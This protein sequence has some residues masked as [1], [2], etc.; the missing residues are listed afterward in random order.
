MLEKKEEWRKPPAELKLSNY[1]VSS[2]GRVKNLK[3]NEII[4]FN[5]YA[6]RNGYLFIRFAIDTGDNTYKAKTFGVHIIIIITFLGK[7]NPDQTV[8][9]MNRIR[10]DN[11]IENLRWLTAKEQAQNRH[12]PK[13]ISTRKIIQYD[14]NNN[15]IKEWDSISLII[16]TLDI[17]DE[18][19]Y[20]ACDKNILLLNSFWKYKDKINLPNEDWTD[21]IINNHDI[22]ASNKGR[23]Q[24]DLSNS[25]RILDATNTKGNGYY[26]VTIGKKQYV[27]QRL[28]CAA[29]KD[30]DVNSKLEINHIDGN[31]KNNNIE[32][33]EIVTRKQNM[34]HAR[35]TGLVPKIQNGRRRPV[36]RSNLD[37]SDEK[38]YATVTEA[39]KENNGDT[40]SISKA[41]K[42]IRKTV[43]GYKYR[44]A[45]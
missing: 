22:K 41:C 34:K 13:T 19:I 39:G 17:S 15:N 7:G 20:R 43:N 25:G 6:R 44:Y 42:G 8:D 26:R 40:C 36:I 35:E 27:I 45:N 5:Q 29:F 9:H 31:K 38:L 32:N 23:V 28:I 21:V 10:D 11:R 30:F 1:M 2:K 18:Q 14:K 4:P 37:G 12:Y 24:I 3:K 16:A 33:L